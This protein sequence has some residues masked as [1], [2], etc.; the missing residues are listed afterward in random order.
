MAVYGK[1]DFF[2]DRMERKRTLPRETTGEFKWISAATNRK[3]V[4]VKSCAK[5][6]NHV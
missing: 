3:N 1:D 5:L 4:G 2:T 6:G